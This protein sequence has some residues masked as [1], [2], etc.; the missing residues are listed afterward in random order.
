MAV[1]TRH[2]LSRMVAKDV[3]NDDDN[4]PVKTNPLLDKILGSRPCQNAAQHASAS[5][6]PVLLI[7]PERHA[8]PSNQ[9]N[10]QDERLQRCAFDLFGVYCRVLV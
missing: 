8:K 4:Y 3:G 7:E 2:V 10:L 5:G 9:G 6:H 1:S